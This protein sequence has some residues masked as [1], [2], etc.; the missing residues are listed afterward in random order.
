M[1]ARSARGSPERP[2]PSATTSGLMTRTMAAIRARPSG[3]R[4]PTVDGATEAEI[5]TNRI[6]IRS[7]TTVAWNLKTSE[8]SSWLWFARTMPIVV[9]AT[10]PESSR[11][12]SA[13]PVRI[14]PMGM[15]RRTTRRV[16]SSSSPKRSRSPA[17][18][19]IRP[20]PRE[21]SGWNVLPKRAAMGVI[22]RR[23]G[24]EPDG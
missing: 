19:R 7:F 15:R 12:R 4:S 24:G 8:T 23:P 16:S 1:N 2:A 11:T 18:N 5:S 6:P 13:T 10:K 9:A 17:S 21:T 14:I 3:T 20:T 22:R